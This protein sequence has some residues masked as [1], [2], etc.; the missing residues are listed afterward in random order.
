MEWLVVDVLRVGAWV[1]D[2]L[3]ADGLLVD[4]LVVVA[5]LAFYGGLASDLGATTE[6]L[7]PRFGLALS[8]ST[9]VAAGA[10]TLVAAAAVVVSALRTGGVGPTVGTVVGFGALFA[11]L[12]ALCFGLGTAVYSLLL[13]VGLDLG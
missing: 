11:A 3:L 5:L 7:H 1:V 4:T 2:A 12:F 9:Y 10:A 13:R 8:L 6:M